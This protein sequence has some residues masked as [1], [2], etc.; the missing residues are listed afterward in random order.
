MPA[1]LTSRIPQIIA[2]SEHRASQ[3]A[4]KTISDI[5]AGAKARSRVDTAA[6]KNAWQAEMNGETSGTVSNPVEHTIYNEYGTRHMGAQPMLAPAVE[7]AAP[8]FE[9]AAGQLYG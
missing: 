9:A 8:E 5:E 1:K 3:I 4:Q 2:E 7:E 6:M